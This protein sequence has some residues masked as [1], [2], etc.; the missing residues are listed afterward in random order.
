MKF[1][2][3]KF[4]AYH[5]SSNGCP[6]IFVAR[7]RDTV[8][9]MLNEADDDMPLIKSDGK[10]LLHCLIETGSGVLNEDILMRLS[11]QMFIE[12]RGISPLE[13]GK[14]TLTLLYC[15]TEAYLI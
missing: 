6:P 7:D 10:T 3:G 2:V 12:W 5:I 13:Y 11:K 14:T 15:G 9:L 4:P 8:M 1:S